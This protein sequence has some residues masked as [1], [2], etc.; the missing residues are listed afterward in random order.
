[1]ESKTATRLNA[2]APDRH[3][4]WAG[5]TIHPYFK[6]LAALLMIGA[7]SM[8]EGAHNRKSLMDTPARIEPWVD[9]ALKRRGRPRRGHRAPQRQL[10]G[11]A[12]AL[13]RRP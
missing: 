8:Y 1:M 2:G 4:R 5:Q 7:F 3:N 9:E 13:L 12:A 6:A 10:R 11:A